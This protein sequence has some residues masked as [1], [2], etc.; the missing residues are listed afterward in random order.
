[1]HGGMQNPE[2][3]KARVEAVEEERIKAQ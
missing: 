1:M 3:G 2:A